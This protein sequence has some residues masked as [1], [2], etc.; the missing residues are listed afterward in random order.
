MMKYFILLVFFSCSKDFLFIGTYVYIYC[1]GER[2]IALLYL[3]LR[4]HSSSGTGRVRKRFTLSILLGHTHCRNQC[5]W[6][7]H[8]GCHVSVG[9]EIVKIVKGAGKLMCNWNLKI[10]R[11]NHFIWS[12]ISWLEGCRWTR[13]ECLNNWTEKIWYRHSWSPEESYWLWRSP[14]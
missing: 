5:W 9:A 11:K 12:D 13:Q 6:I 2:R 14:A 3:C 1:K 7:T 10:E 8:A 4:S